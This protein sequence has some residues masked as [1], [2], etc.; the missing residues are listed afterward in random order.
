MNRWFSKTKVTESCPDLRTHATTLRNPIIHD[1]RF[2]ALDK[3]LV[4]NEP[5]NW[6]TIM[7]ARN[8]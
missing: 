3:T 5:S 2:S 7:R 8:L 4:Y 1:V 6:K